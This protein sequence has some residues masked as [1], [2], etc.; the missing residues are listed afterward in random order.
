[1]FLYI[2]LIYCSRGKLK[3]GFGIPVSDL[4]PHTEHGNGAETVT[5]PSPAKSFG[6]GS[7][8]LVFDIYSASYCRDIW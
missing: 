8:T 1:M 7:T 4:E 6:S 3:L 5:A 2:S